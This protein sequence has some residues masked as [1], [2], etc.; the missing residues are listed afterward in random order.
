VTATAAR[1]R[2]PSVKFSDSP[3]IF[4]QLNVTRQDKFFPSRAVHTE[5]MWQRRPVSNN[6]A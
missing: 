1:G 3:F 4:A 6:P 5:A 2:L